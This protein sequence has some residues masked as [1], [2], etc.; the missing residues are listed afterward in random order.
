MGAM[1]VAAVANG[2]EG[3]PVGRAEAG[4]AVFGVVRRSTMRVGCALRTTFGQ[5]A[6]ESARVEGMQVR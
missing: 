6:A 3:V 1:A 5:R 4:G 2:V